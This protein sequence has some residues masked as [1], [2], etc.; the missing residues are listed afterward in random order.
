[1]C[2]GLVKIHTCHPSESVHPNWQKCGKNMAIDN[3]VF[4]QGAMK[5]SEQWLF[6]IYQ[7]IIMS[8]CIPIGKLLQH[9]FIVMNCNTRY[10]IS[11]KYAHL[12]DF[13][14]Y[15]IKWIAI[16][17]TLFLK[18][19]LIYVISDIN[20]IVHPEVSHLIC[21]FTILLSIWMYRFGRVSG[22]N[23]KHLWLTM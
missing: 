7:D 10:F 22:L 16:L 6:V 14:H 20:Q 8:T 23:M 9:V 3:A 1:M 4:S 5:F 17:D 12:C 13:W 21:I 19:M 15:I 2:L 11:E 18:S